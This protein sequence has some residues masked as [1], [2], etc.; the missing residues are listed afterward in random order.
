M[1]TRDVLLITS[2][3]GAEHCAATIAEIVAS[4]VEVAQ[5]RRAGLTALR[6]MQFAVVIVEEGLVESDA[7]WA[8]QIW[9]TAGLALPLQFNFSISGCARLAREVKSALARRQGELTVARREAATE[10]ENELK[11]SV[12]GMLLQSELAL[13]EPTVSKT[14]EP[15]LRHLVELAGSIRERLRREAA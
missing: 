12:T 2:I 4:R 1:R 7:E 15:K 5:T 6:R 11:S 9:E 10:I 3:N 14:L 13:R 8:D